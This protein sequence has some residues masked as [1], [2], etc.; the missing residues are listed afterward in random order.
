MGI[1]KDIKR[2]MFL[3]LSFIII[4][5]AISGCSSKKNTKDF[6]PS[7]PEFG[8]TKEDRGIGQH[9][10]D[11]ASNIATDH[12]NTSPLEPTKVIVTFYID[13]Q[14]IEFDKS[15][16]TLEGLISKYE[17]Y[18]GSSNIYLG[19]YYGQ[20]TNRNANYTIRV[21][22]TNV[23]TF[24][25]ETGSVGKINT[26]EENKEDITMHYRD[27]ESRLNVLNIK[28]ER[29]TALLKKSEK[30]EDIISLEN[31]LS[32]IIYQKENL[33]GVLKNLD[34]KVD[35]STI[36]I[37]LQEVQKLT[38]KEDSKTNFGQRISN[39][40]S[41]SLHYFRIGSEN[42]IIELIY[43]LPTIII[44]ILLVYAVYKGIR[45]YNKK[46]QFSEDTKISDIDKK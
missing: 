40:I 25:A 27:T 22:K 4:L 17:G 7:S 2:F 19:N 9:N 45:I 23:N 24:M 10:D 26:Q 33:T 16:S 36:T 13:M 20:N 21:P 30:M 39:A 34:D 32:D 12:P 46:K 31:T 8:A 14:T 35:F 15:I 37:S 29:I 43:A 18:V 6:S 38:T 5:S 42:L 41:D 11:V 3:T 1:V 28:E 44:L